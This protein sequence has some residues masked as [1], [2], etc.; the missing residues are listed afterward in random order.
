M[1]HVPIYAAHLYDAV[2]LYANALSQIIRGSN[3]TDPADILEAA[4]DGRSLFHKIIEQRKYTS[5][6]QKLINDQLLCNAK[7]KYTVNY[8]WKLESK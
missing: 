1:Q 7:V 2:M 5:K 6:F 8:Y 4:K 3:L